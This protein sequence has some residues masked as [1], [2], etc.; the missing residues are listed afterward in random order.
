MIKGN[1]MIRRGSEAATD[2]YFGSFSIKVS[3]GQSS[4]H[5]SAQPFSNVCLFPLQVEPKEVKLH[6]YLEQRRQQIK[7]QREEDFVLQAPPRPPEGSAEVEISGIL[8]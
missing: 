8:L 4:H 6:V 3:L 7:I 1:E 2:R 5:Q